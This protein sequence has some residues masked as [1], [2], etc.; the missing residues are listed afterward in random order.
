MLHE[1]IT[2]RVNDY[3]NLVEDQP[4]TILMDNVES[5]YVGTVGVSDGKTIIVMKSGD[6]F[7]TRMPYADVI[8]IW[9]TCVE[10][11]NINQ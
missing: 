7:T 1:F 6:S 3:D 11:I 5:V 8:D 10:P 2:M 9:K 4:A